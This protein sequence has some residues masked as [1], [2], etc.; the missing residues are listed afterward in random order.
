[1]N[2]DWTQKRQEFLKVIDERTRD[3]VALKLAEQYGET[4]VDELLKIY[5]SF[6]TISDFA[7]NKLQ[8][9]DDSGKPTGQPNYGLTPGQVKDIA[10]TVRACSEQLHLI[11][12]RATSRSEIDVNE[13]LSLLEAEL[14]KQF[15]EGNITEKELR[16]VLG[17][18][19]NAIIES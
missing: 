17:D 12:G 15:D 19:A 14:K 18:D 1:M 2:E 13:D 7:M 16:E 10:Y 8:T 9:V 3:Q 4:E 6:R 5:R 11:R